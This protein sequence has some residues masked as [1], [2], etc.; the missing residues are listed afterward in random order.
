MS[1]ISLKYDHT[2]KYWKETAAR[3]PATISH[4]WGHQYSFFFFELHEPVRSLP[5]ALFFRHDNFIMV[6]MS[7][8]LSFPLFLHLTYLAFKGQENNSKVLPWGKKN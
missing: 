7:S 2:K 5:A 4:E 3:L 1:C 6:L 8:F